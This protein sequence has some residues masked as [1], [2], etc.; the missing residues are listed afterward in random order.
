MRVHAAWLL[1]VLAIGLGLGYA[2]FAPK[3][4]VNASVRALDLKVI[5]GGVYRVRSA[6]DGDTVILENGLHV[7][8]N[9]FNSPESGRWV[10]DYSPMAKE[11]TAKNNGLVEGRRVRLK[12]AK[13]P[14]DP[15]GRVVANVFLVPDDD[16]KPEIEIREVLLKEGFGKAMGLGVSP[17]EYATL[18]SWQDEAKSNGTGIWGVQ[19]PKSEVAKEFCAS[20]SS[21]TYH[22]CTCS[23]AKRISAANMHEYASAE[24]AEAAGLKPCA[25]CLKQSRARQ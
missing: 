16:G 18:K 7:R 14:I 23:V 25:Q 20:S 24:E 12:L 11:A 4:T 3:A 21:K 19:P 6:V 22:R 15:H 2:L 8:Y 9:G 17:N 1:V 13:D 10:R 5:D